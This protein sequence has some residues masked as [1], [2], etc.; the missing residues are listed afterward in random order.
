MVVA[1]VSVPGCG[2]ILLICEGAQYIML[3]LFDVL[4]AAVVVGLFQLEQDVY[5]IELLIG[6]QPVFFICF[7]RGHGRVGFVRRFCLFYGWLYLVFCFCL[8]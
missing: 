4:T 2:Q 6:V 7:L 5:L 1:Q 8:F 3:L